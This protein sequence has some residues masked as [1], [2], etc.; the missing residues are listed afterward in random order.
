MS[1]KIGKEILALLI[2]IAAAICMHVYVFQSG[3]Q[4]T[5]RGTDATKQLLFF[6][7]L[8]HGLFQE[9]NFFWSWSYGLGGDIFG[10][11]NY[12]YSA[13]PFFW[14]MLLFDIDTLTDVAGWVYKTSIL[15]HFAAMAFLFG[16]LR[17]HGRSLTASIIGGLLYGGTFLFAVNSLAFDFMLDPYV[18]LPLCVLS[19]DLYIDKNKHW[20]FILAVAFM[21]ANSFY[22]GFISSVY[23]VMYAVYRY[24]DRK[25]SIS[26]KGF[27]QYGLKFSGVY[28]MGLGASFFAFLPAVYQFLQTDRLQKNYDIPFLFDVAFYKNIL[29]VLFFPYGSTPQTEFT[30][31]LPFL[32]F[33]LMLVGFTFKKYM[34]KKVFLAVIIMM[35]LLPFMYSFFNGMSA[36]QSRWLYLV[37]FTICLTVPFFLDEMVKMEKKRSLLVG[38]GIL[39]FA[40][41]LWVT[42]GEKKPDYLRND[43]IVLAVGMLSALALI[44]YTRSQKWIWSAMLIGTVL[45][46]GMLQHTIYY[47]IKLGAPAVQQDANRAYLSQISFDN[48]EGLELIETI[49]DHDDSFYRILWD[50]PDVEYNTPMYYGYKGHSAYQSLVSKNVHQFFKEDYNILQFDS[51]SLYKNYDQRLYLE[52]I[53]GTKYYITEKSPDHIPYGYEKKWESANWNVYENQHFLPVGFMYEKWVTEEEFQRLNPAEKDQLLLEAAVVKEEVDVG[54]NLDLSTL[55]TETLHAGLDGIKLKQIEKHGDNHFEALEAEGNELVIPITQPREAGELLVE[56][57]IE[58]LDGTNFTLTLNG[59]TLEKRPNHLTWSYPKTNFVINAGWNYEE[60]EFRIGLSKGNFRID[61]LHVY[62][63]SYENAAERVDDLR[64]TELQDM[65]YTEESI[66]GGIVAENDGIFYLSVPNSKGWNVKID[67]EEVEH[68]EVNHTF[69][70][71]PLEKGTYRLEM[72]YVTP[73]FKEGVLLSI[74]SIISAALLTL[75]KRRSAKSNK[76]S[77]VKG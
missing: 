72:N 22:F 12:Y 43:Y 21:I 2:L 34:A 25:R 30:I 75:W 39:F 47:G 57:D 58:S 37:S 27:F 19:L 60:D 66:S 45:L 33:L 77:I 71:I 62:F 44:L 64:M 49:Q 35:L 59:K 73:F 15:K 31:G 32:A 65:S 10:Q 69:I 14:L 6:K 23:L 48:Q 4:L 63:N 1:R 53:T 50:H 9:G 24:F 52:T 76:E 17:Y 51:L 40:I 3:S 74:L 16:L 55:N 18:W 28:L 13:S 54:E 42:G 5:T 56:I 67:G 26:A 7:F 41:F 29:L 8:L 70:G 38:A 11:F 68:L 61:D 36:M 20:P 46:N